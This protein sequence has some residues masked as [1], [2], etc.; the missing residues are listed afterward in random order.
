[1]YP[2]TNTDDDFVERSGAAAMILMSGSEVASADDRLFLSGMNAKHFEGKLAPRKSLDYHRLTNQS[3]P[4]P[5]FMSTQTV[6][7]AAIYSQ[8]KAS[9]GSEDVGGLSV[10]QELEAGTHVEIYWPGTGAIVPEERA[11]LKELLNGTMLDRE[12]Y[13][14]SS[15]EVGNGG[16]KSITVREFLDSDTVDP[17]L[18]RLED[19]MCIGGHI[20]AFSTSG[21]WWTQ[22]LPC[23]VF[24]VLPRFKKLVRIQRI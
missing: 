1:M 4:E 9:W 6:P 24:E 15:W 10:L 12:G 18:N 20:V 16:G 3:G 2:P 17:C 13:W 22:R 5:L 8:A 21:W 23:N 19:T 11:A 7:Y 14:P